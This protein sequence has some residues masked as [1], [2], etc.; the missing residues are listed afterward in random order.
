MAT[1][2]L[3]LAYFAN[4]TISSQVHF[5]A[6]AMSSFSLTTEKHPVRRPLSSLATHLRR[7]SWLVLFSSYYEEWSNKC[8]YVGLSRVCRLRVIRIFTQ[9]WQD[10]LGHVVAVHSVGWRNTTPT[11]MWL[12]Q[13]T[14]PP[15][16]NKGI[17]S[18]ALFLAFVLACLAKNYPS[19]MEWDQLSE[20]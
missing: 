12:G 6:N 16:G 8:R 9:E 2:A 1:F 7:I 4:T 20:F 14:F 19:W 15:V 13:L 11:S 10:Y 18:L 17:S 3:M 5:S